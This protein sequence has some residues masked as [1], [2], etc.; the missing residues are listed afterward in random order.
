MINSILIAILIFIFPFFFVGGLG[1]DTLRTF[2]EIWNLGHLLFFAVVA[3]LASRYYLQKNINKI[4]IFF[5]ILLFSAILGGAIEIIQLG[6]PGRD[7]SWED[8]FRDLAGALI[9]LFWLGIP[10]SKSFRYLLWYR[11]LAVVIFCFTCIPLGRASV[12]D[13]RIYRDFPVLSGFENEY[14]LR[15]WTGAGRMSLVKQPVSQGRHAARIL[16][17]TTQYSGISLRYF[18]HNWRGKSALA[19]DIYNPGDSLV[20]HYRVHDDLHYGKNRQ[21]QNRYNGTT[22]LHAGWNN[23]VIN[24][25]DIKNG[26][27]GRKMNLANIQGLGMFVMQQKEERTFILD[28]VRLL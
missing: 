8:V 11:V 24:M 27:V 14:E 3:L 2:N 19:F 4:L 12:D 1:D 18:N 26:P 20:L 10:L 9:I 17:T 6:I 16:L 25:E 7:C 5:R 22:E 13:Y 23:I 21:Y 15:R 28:N